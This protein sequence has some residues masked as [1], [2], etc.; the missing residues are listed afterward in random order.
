[1]TILT[2]TQAPESIHEATAM[3]VFELLIPRG[4]VVSSHI[5]AQHELCWARIGTY[6]MEVLRRVWHLSPA[7][8]LWVPAGVPHS[9]VADDELVLLDTKYA[10]SMCPI[11]WDQPRLLRMTGLM[12]SLLEHLADPTLAPGDRVHAEVVLY[13]VLLRTESPTQPLAV[14]RDPRAKVVADALLAEPGDD[15]SLEDWADLASSSARTLGRLFREEVSLS[16][17][18]WRHQVRMNA[19]VAFLDAG[20]AVKVVSRR[21]GYRDTGSFISAFERSF[22]FTPGCWSNRDVG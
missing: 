16:F 3:G 13:D 5:H 17:S 6:R 21:V 2:R 15:R 11:R 22:G 4:E 14:P 10:A 18:G 9:F 1:V 12:A 19:A 20:E 7:S 8:A